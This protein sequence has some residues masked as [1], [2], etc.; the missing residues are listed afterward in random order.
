M[1]TVYLDGEDVEFSGDPPANLQA[2]IDIISQHLSQ[3]ARLLATC[4][5][6]GKEVLTLPPDQYP[7]TCIEV[8]MTSTTVES[9]MAEKVEAALQ[10]TV[11]LVTELQL[12]A[13]EILQKPWSETL[14]SIDQFSQSL[15][16]LHQIAYELHQYAL[17]QSLRWQP[18]NEQF[19]KS[20][21]EALSVFIAAAQRTDVASVSDIVATQIIPLV[22]ACRETYEHEVLESFLCLQSAK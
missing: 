5:V 4:E 13:T 11:G 1:K 14:Q 2:L 20:T 16:P 18:K 21:E 10:S 7:P 12:F 9:L 15:A 22:Q 8:R 6:D 19:L 3:N 17:Q